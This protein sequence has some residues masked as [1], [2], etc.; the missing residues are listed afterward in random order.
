[1]KND[2]FHES[3]TYL[4]NL[5]RFGMVFGLSNIRNIVQTLD[6]PQERLKTI[7]IG[8]TNGKGSTAERIPGGIVYLPPRHVVHRENSD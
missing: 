7:H 8:G 4:Y 2:T 6:N 5:Q 3:L 1:M